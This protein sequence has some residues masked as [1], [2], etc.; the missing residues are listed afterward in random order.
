MG[1][2][3]IAKN[4]RA[5]YDFFLTEKFEAGLELQGTEVKSLRLGKVSIGESHI[6]IDKN[7]EAWANNILIPHY[8]FGN[9]N[10]HQEDRRR[11]LL[12]H[13]KEIEKIQHLMSTQRLTL[14]PTMIYFKGSKIKLEIALAKGKKLYDKRATEAKKDVERKL[15]RQIYE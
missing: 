13:K 14:V 5:T 4:K 3:V 7:G 9:F 11:K 12:L 1:I 8:P 15:Q 6:T 10:N 2:K